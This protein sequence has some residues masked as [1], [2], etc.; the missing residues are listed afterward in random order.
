[1][2]APNNMNVN[3]EN[4]TPQLAKLWLEKN[5]SN[6]PISENTVTFYANEMSRG[7]WHETNQGIGFFKD[8]TLADGQHR[9]NAVIVSGMTVKMQ[10][11]RG[12][13]QGAM[14][15]IDGGKKRTA[16]DHLHIHYGISNANAFAA[17]ARQIVS[18]FFGYQNF[19]LS[20]EVLHPVIKYYE[21]DMAKVIPA[22]AG[23]RPATR[24]WVHACIVI[25]RHR[26]PEIIDELLAGFSTGEGL[27]VNTPAHTFREWLIA[28]TSE[29]LRGSYKRPA[30]ESGL[31]ILYHQVKGTSYR[32]PKQGAQGHSYFV[33]MEKRFVD[34]IRVEIAHLISR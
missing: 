34:S 19:P 16:A 22:V 13:D 9:L 5:T 20:A 11:T 8:G 25:A 33:P 15:G 27:R 30:I 21:A 24:A 23:F 17:C 6:R 26:H 1:M 4:I 3:I 29:H 14:T 12:M 31:N 18:T 2:G 32:C 10:V 28:G 7:R